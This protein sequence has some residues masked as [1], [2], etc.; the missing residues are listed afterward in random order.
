MKRRSLQEALKIDSQHL[1]SLIAYGRILLARQK[2][3]EAARIFEYSFCLEP[4]LFKPITGGLKYRQQGKSH[5]L[6]TY[7]ARNHSKK[8]A[9]A[10]AIVSALLDLGERERAFS[11][12][13]GA[14]T[15]HDN[16]IEYFYQFAQVLAEF[17]HDKA[18]GF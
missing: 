5:I 18:L 8:P 14:V 16:F 6:V 17:H 2:Y 13:H 1:D 10:M 3:D 12:L 4:Q 7:I 9:A 11:V 15:T